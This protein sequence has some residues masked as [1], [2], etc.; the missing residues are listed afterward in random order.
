MAW[1]VIMHV[2]YC[3]QGQSIKDMCH[4][5]VEWG[6]DGIEFRR[7]RN[8]VNE[9]PKD[10]IKSIEKAVKKTGLK[11]VLFGGPGADLANPDPAIR[12]QQIKEMIE[13]FKMA[14]NSFELSVCNTMA[15]SLL[16]NDKSIPYSNYDMHGSFAATPDNW[17]W[18]SEGFKILG[19][20]AEELNFKFAFEAHMGY[21]HDLPEKAKYLVDMIDSASVGV[22]LDYGNSV[23]FKDKPSLRKAIEVTSDKL[24]YVHLKNSVGLKDGSRFPTALSEGE[25]NH[26]EYI[27][28]LKEFKYN[29]PICIEAPRPGDREWYAKEDIKYIKSVIEDLK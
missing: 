18:A 27:S 9:T 16:N 6:F 2:N 3:E 14:A 7:K 26:R 10:Y 28:L 12:D 1:D 15:G 8:G 25:I 22:N 17:K 20:M 19:K 29:G 11:K 5:A 23:Y 21:I 13:F 4:K 24:Y